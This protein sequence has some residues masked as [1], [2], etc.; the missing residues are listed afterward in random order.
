MSKSKKKLSLSK[1]QLHLITE[2]LIFSS[3]ADICADWTKKQQRKFA[4]LAIKL[5][6]ETKNL[7]LADD[8][9]EFHESKD[10]VNLAKAFNLK[11]K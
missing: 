6:G 5:K 4:K 9:A 8:R 11:V 10:T 7:W 2:A 3:S 1:K